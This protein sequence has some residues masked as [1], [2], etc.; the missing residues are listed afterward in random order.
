MRWK[1]SIYAVAFAAVCAITPV[2]AEDLKIG[3]LF[4]LSGPMALIGNEALQASEVARDMINERGGVL[5]RKVMY[6]VSDA[7]APTAANAEATRLIVRE[8][9]PLIAGSYASSLSL[10]ASEV[11]ERE[12]ALYW[13]TIAVADKITQRN[14]RNIVR[15]T[16]NASMMGETAADFAK[17]LSGKLGKEPK[18]LRVAVISEDSE[19]G[20]SV[21]DAAAK[22]VKSLGL[23]LVSNEHYSRTVTDLSSLVLSLKA[24]RPDAVIATSYL[25]D[26]ILFWRQARELDLNVGAMIG[27]GTGY[28]LPDF[29][30]A[31]GANTEGLFD[32]DA[33]A[34]PNVSNLPPATQKLYGEFVE[35]FRAK[36]KRDPGPLAL[37]S[38][39]GFWTLFTDVIPRA[40]STEID[41]L[42]KAAYETDLPMGTLLTGAG[43][44][45]KPLGDKEQGQNTRAL[46]SVMQWQGG[47]LQTVWPKDVAGAEIK[48]V[49]LQKWR[50]R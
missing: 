7:P 50:D 32:I 4:P 6:A 28:A 45:L 30:S 31:T 36:T 40:G 29:L 26:A 17:E 23:N 5:G 15:L 48:Q 42:R 13:E 3:V 25:N 34:S 8:K 20:Q 46:I 9:V 43:V 35:R 44:R 12:G 22:R 41:A 14:Y 16:F 37:I 27:I 49:P 11:A 1:S 38:F 10:A 33:P 21:G 18:D 39:G 19:F 2:H 47:K 24:A